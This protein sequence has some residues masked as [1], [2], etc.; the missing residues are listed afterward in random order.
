MKISS[1]VKDLF[2]FLPIFLL[3]FKNS[4][5]ILN[6]MHYPLYKYMYCKYLLPFCDLH[7]QP[8]IFDIKEITAPYFHFAASLKKCNDSSYLQ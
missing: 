1:F 2:N 5:Y 3:I 6:K 7:I 4:L 8:W